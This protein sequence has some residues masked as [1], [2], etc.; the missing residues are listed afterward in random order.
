MID[1]DGK[2]EIRSGLQSELPGT[3]ISL[4]PLVLSAGLDVGEM[5]FAKDT[6]RLFIGHSPVI[7][8]PN[9]KR[10]TLPY[11]NVEIL[12]ENSPRNRELF[13]DFVRDQNEDAFFLPTILAI[14]PMVD[15]TY[16][17]DTLNPSKF[18]GASISAIVEYHAFTDVAG[19]PVSQG[20][21]RIL[22]SN[23]TVE[24]N[25]SEKLVS[26][27]FIDPNTNGDLLTFGCRYDSGSYY[28][29]CQNST[30]YPIKLYIR[31]ILLTRF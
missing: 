9:F 13:N 3:P 7:S 24:L 10:S 15:L 27:T 2:V 29:Q 20:T 31:R 22:G 11:E 25:D 18:D 17:V 6:A 23:G 12:T 1:I 21:L 19:Q 8:D 30:N 4:D 14:G 16:P 5:G 26:P 28:L